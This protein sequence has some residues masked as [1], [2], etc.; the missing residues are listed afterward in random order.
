MTSREVGT[1]KSIVLGAA[2]AVGL[3]TAAQAGDNKLAFSG[4]ANL[5]TDYM[6]R[7]YSASAK[8]PAAQVEFDATYGMFYAGIW[9][10]NTY[11]G[12]GI[13]LD[14]YAGIT[15]TW[16]NITFDV[17][18][19]YYTYPGAS[20]LDYLEVKTAAKYST[21]NLTLSIGN[22][23]S[24]D[25][26]GAGTTSDAV[27]GGAGY[28]FAGKLFNFFSPSISGALGYQW[29]R[30]RLRR[31]HILEHRP[32]SRVSGPLVCRRALL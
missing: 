2:L 5:T 6:F 9:G 25:N 4:S 19:L 31:L 30:K 28:A 17:A 23:W 18:A 10:S 21:G 29:V 20:E 32:D 13:E 16:K 27:E 15:P 12:D 26:F 24:P 11:F 3:A 8:N 1:I 14:Y 7:S 22:W